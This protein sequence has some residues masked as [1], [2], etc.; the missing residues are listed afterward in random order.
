MVT[1]FAFTEARLRAS[2]APKKRRTYYRDTKLPGLQLCITTAGSRTY[3]FVHRINGRPTRMRIGR[4]G[5]IS[6]DQAR[7]AAMELAGDV[8]R[9]HDPQAARRARRQVATVG[10]MFAYY[11]EQHARPHKRTWKVDQQQYDRY[12]KRRWHSRKLDTIRRRDVQALHTKIGA[13]HGHYAANRLRSLLHSMFTV[14]I[15]GGLW[16]GPNPVA[17]IKKFREKQR[18]RFLSADELGRFFRSLAVETS[19]IVRDYLLLLLLTAARRSNLLS[20]A[21]R[22]IDFDRAVWAIPDTKAGTPLTIPLTPEALGV[23]ARRRDAAGDSVWVFPSS[24]SASG[25]LQ[26]PEKIWKRVLA[27]AKLTDCRLHDLRRTAA[28]W[29]ALSG[30][31]LQV[32]GKS[33]GHKRTATTEI[34]AKLTLDPIR[35]SVERA[36]VAMYEAGGVRLLENKASNDE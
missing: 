32:I 5:D 12:V 31:S 15:D 18:E 10:E 16:Q 33:L 14:A 36:T 9:G 23:L 20:M 3:Y 26:C 8:S 7:K 22:D 19:E 28:S 24:K 29:Q 13:K 34:Y 21:W 11:I 35:Q 27:R 25:H 1:Q 6:L 2:E 30:S 4:Q 17:G